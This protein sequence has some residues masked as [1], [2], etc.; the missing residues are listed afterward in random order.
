MKLYWAIVK[1]IVKA[2]RRGEHL[3]GVLYFWARN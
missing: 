1:D 3:A 2:H